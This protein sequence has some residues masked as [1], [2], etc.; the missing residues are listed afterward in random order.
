MSFNYDSQ[1]NYII[2]YCWVIHR[3]TILLALLITALL[4]QEDTSG[5]LEVGIQASEWI[6]PDADGKYF[7]MDF[8]RGKILL[9]N[10]VD[11]DVFEMIEPFNDEVNRLFS[12]DKCDGLAIV[13]CKATWIPNF[14]IR[15][16]AAAKANKFETEILFDYDTKLRKSWG[17][18]ENSNN[19]I[20]LDKDRICRAIVRGNITDKKQKELI[21]LIIDLQNEL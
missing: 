2:T 19:V 13:D 18:K 21:K 3:K 9:I 11:P 17:L 15:K 14:L 10:Y 5:K 7:N 1:A 20:I 8:W 12:R 4:A 16:V 6:F